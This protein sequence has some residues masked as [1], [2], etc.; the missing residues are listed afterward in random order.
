MRGLLVL[1]LALWPALA[2]AQGT[3]SLVADSVTVDAAGRLIAEGNVEAFYDGSRLSAAR[4]VYDQA[5]DRLSIDGP[6]FLQG[7]DGEIVTAERAELDPRLENGLLRG[8][9]LVLERQLQLTAGRIDRIDG[10][11]SALTRTAATACQVCD[12]RAPLWEI[13]AAQV[14]HDEVE[15]QLY[16]ENAT[17]LI[18]GV[19]VLWIPAMRLPDPTVERATGLLVPRIRTTDRLGLGIKLPYFVTLGPSRDLTLTPYLSRETTSVEARYREAWLSGEIEATGA[20][21]RDSLRPGEVRGYLFAD[22]EWRLAPGR[23]LTFGLEASSDPDY[24]TDY[25]ISDRDRLTSFVGYAAVTAD[26]LAEAHLAYHRTFREDEVDGALPPWE[27][28]AAYER[29]MAAFGG[30]LT[31]GGAAEALLRTTDGTGDLARDVARAGAFAG[32]QRQAILPAGFVL[33]G[34]GSVELGFYRI[35]DDPA[36]DRTVTRVTPAVQATLRWPLI[37]RGTGGT[38]HLLEPLLAV[39]WSTNRGGAVPNEDSAVVEFDEG[40][41]DALTRYP[42]EDAREDG[43]RVAV[44]LSY[45]L[46][47]ADG[48]ELGLTAGRIY[49]AEA[50]TGFDLASGLNGLSSDWLLS[51]RLDLPLGITARARTVFD[52]DLEFDKTEARL[53]WASPTVDLSATYVYLPVARSEGREESIAEWTVDGRWQVTPSWSLAAEGRYDLSDARPV[54]AGF[55]VGWRN[56]C[57]EVDVSISRSYTSGEEQDP[58][59]DFGL[60]VSLLGFSAEGVGA[61]PPGRCR[62]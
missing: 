29:R 45:T 55:G 37:A 22:G 23:T 56:E 13:R 2:S 1:L 35:A 12:G 46:I 39:A 41:L 8:A 31:F 43:A 53:A 62:N 9:R 14:V 17:F 47:A 18:R 34:G 10:R 20:V 50:D 51:A 36:F 52:D 32:W 49:R 27:G 25:G 3:A 11:Y 7:P 57:V 21:S 33:S 54:T 16:F 58:T 6:I 30:T 40:N 15:R 19:P 28:R 59:T 60:E 61:V 26:S 4:I 24:L 44:G 5:A 38:A 48:T 42:G